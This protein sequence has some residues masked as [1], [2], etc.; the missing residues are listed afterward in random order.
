MQTGTTD[1]DYRP[2]SPRTVTFGSNDRPVWLKTVHFRAIVHFKNHPLSSFWAVRF[3]PEFFINRFIIS[4]IGP[5]MICLS[6]KNNFRRKHPKYEDSSLVNSRRNVQ[7]IPVDD[8]KKRFDGK[9]P[10]NGFR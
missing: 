1:W 5:W 10:M 2:L 6:E 7:S 8:L 9:H 4:I 3:G